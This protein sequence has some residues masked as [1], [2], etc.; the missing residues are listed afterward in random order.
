[1][2]G[3]WETAQRFVIKVE[4]WR[5][6][7]LDAEAANEILVLWRR[8]VFANGESVGVFLDRLGKALTTSDADSAR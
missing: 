7:G 1:M 8:Y 5:G 4:A 2:F 6:V 3:G